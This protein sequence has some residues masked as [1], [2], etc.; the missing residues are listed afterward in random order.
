[1]ARPSLPDPVDLLRRRLVEQVRG[2]FN[3]AAS[4]E[5]PVP[6]SDDALF[7]RDT[8]IRMV[9][10]DVVSMMV[11]GMA[12]LLLQMLHPHALRGVLDF[13]DFR[14][15][16]HGRL[17]RTARF[18]ATTS[19]GHREAAQ[20]AVD[21]VNSIHT[22]VQGTLPDGTQYSATDPAT[23]AWVHVAEAT[24]FLAAYVRFVQPDMPRAAQDEYFRQ[25]ALIARKLGADPVPETKHE[26]DVLF[27]RMR[28][29][30]V[31]SPQ[32]REIARLV[33]DSRPEGTPAAA[34]KLVAAAA[35]DLLP[36]FARSMLGLGSPGIAAL[37]AR[38][39]TWGIAKTLRWAFR[40]G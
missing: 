3:D 24:S 23:L 27:R 13:S 32:A 39:G 5:T 10:A 1:M 8:P 21:R 16:M 4:G 17:R 26:A 25:F 7:A 14:A 9:H 15:D 19:F 12:A 22:R 37:P 34:Q 18:I 38:A 20:H 31:A 30:L 36:P 2:E 35:V 33:L 11:G 6:P 40:Q 29:E 28:G